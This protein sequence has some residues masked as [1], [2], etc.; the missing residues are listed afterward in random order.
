[1]ERRALA[2]AFD[3][4]GAFNDVV[5][6][7]MR[8]ASE[9]DV[10]ARLDRLLE[11]RLRRPRRDAARAAAVALVPEQRAD[12]APRV[13]PA[14]VPVIFLG[15]AAFLL[16]VVLSRIVSVQRPQIAA[17]KALGYSNARHRRCTT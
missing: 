4:D 9:P 13:R 1:M 12:A 2:S 14:I 17:L 5:L 6:K 15:V 10:I 3:M 8:G 11:A 7:L 16:N